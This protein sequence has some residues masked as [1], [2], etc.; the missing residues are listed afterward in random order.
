MKL[1][2]ADFKE[3]WAS[4]E[5]KD[6]IYSAQEREFA[7]H[8]WEIFNRFKLNRPLPTKKSLLNTRAR[9]FKAPAKRK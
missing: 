5:S 7:K 6:K 4:F 3:F 8:L 1:K 9:K 2:M